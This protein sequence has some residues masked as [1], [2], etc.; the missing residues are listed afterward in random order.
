VASA[1]LVMTA[2]DSEECKHEQSD[3]ITP[4]ASAEEADFDDVIVGTCDMEDS[5]V[6]AS[7]MSMIM[8]TIMILLRLTV[9]H[10]S[11]SLTM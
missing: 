7:M 3:L 5:S 6:L 2:E 1:W 11:V 9:Y 8:M 10:K 4:E